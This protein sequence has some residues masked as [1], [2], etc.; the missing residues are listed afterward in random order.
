MDVKKR[1]KDLLIEIKTAISNAKDLKMLEDVRVKYFG[2]KS[3][4][5]DLLKSMGSLPSNERPAFGK[6]INDTKSKTFTMLQDKIKDLQGNIDSQ[7]SSKID[8]TLQ[9]NPFSV[10]SLHPLTQVWERIHTIFTRLGFGVAEGPDIE[11]DYYNFGALNFPQDHPARD[12]QDTFFLN[13]LDDKSQPFLLRTHTS[14]VQIR[15]METHKPPFQIIIPGS[16][17]RCDCDV[18]HT[19]MFHQVEGLVVGENVSFANLKGVLEAFV[20]EMFGANTKVRFRPSFF[21]FTEPSAEIDIS[22]VVCK[23]KGCRLCKDTGWLEIL[24]SGMVHPNVLKSGGYDSEKYTGFAFGMGL[25]R[26]ALLLFGIDDIRL[27][28][29]NDVRFLK[30]F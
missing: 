13:H 19:P 10:G 22:C 1:L 12:A 2:K 16:V 23:G 15:F 3:E 5:T 20:C 27:L 21:P 26:I 30:Q 14:P 9:G 11:T 4:L 6:L 8:V 24:G 18:S 28:F 25:E 17:Y 29:E 7:S